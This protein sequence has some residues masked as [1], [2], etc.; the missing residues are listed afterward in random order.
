M[1]EFVD[2]KLRVDVLV[3]EDLGRVKEW[4]ERTAATWL[5]VEEDHDAN[6]HVH[7]YMRVN[8]PS[9][10]RLR[11]AF[12]NVFGKTHSGNKSY[13]MEVMW[14]EEFH[15]GYFRYLCKG[16]SLAELPIV[17]SRSGIQFSVEGVIEKFHQEYYDEAERRKSKRK[18]MKKEETIEE[19]VVAICRKR[20]YTPVHRLAIVET[21]YDVYK[22][23][24]KGYT[25]YEFTRKFTA[26]MM[27]LD[28]DGDFK[29]E[30]T[31]RLCRL[32]ER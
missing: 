24:A 17:I 25:S 14:D 31:V 32:T 8:L 30:E 29:K 15:E 9:I 18:R 6:R 10:A 7:A 12:R 21:M 3:D 11:S 2:C 27:A 13:S 19:E 4:I 5:L 16:N 26:V 22:E 23:R 20:K 28:E 1:S